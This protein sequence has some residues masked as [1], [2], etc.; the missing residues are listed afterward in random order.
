MIITC[1]HCQTRYQVTYEAIGATGRKVQCATCSRN[2]QQEPPTEADELH[3]DH[4]EAQIDEDKLDEGFAE[5][6]RAVAL[7]LERR[8]EEVA[9]AHSV[10]EPAKVDPA[11]QRKR[12]RAF[13][14]RQ[15][16]QF[17]KL[18][19]AR[20]RRAARLSGALI[21]A[22]L[23]VG[24]VFA[25]TTIVQQ[26]PAMAGVYSA[27]GLGVNV[28]G[29][30]F[31]DVTTL[32]TLVD[33]K[34]LLI[35]TATIKG[36]VNAP[37][38]VPPVVVSLIDGGG[39]PIYQWSVKP[40]AGDL[41][42]GETSALKTQL[43]LPPGDVARVKLAFAGGSDTTNDPP[44]AADAAPAATPHAPAEPALPTEHH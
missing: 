40:D 20:L 43:T 19:L 2:W 18:P 23:L 32:R 1:P 13:K 3:K 28:V 26:F 29:L 17:A 5:E 27:V 7:E 41:M 11:V 37:V 16:S 9:R 24:A 31:Q 38:P 35:V 4:L 34:E 30:T 44:A 42:A 8:L 21:L 6:E 25:R 36:A 22:S 12:Q 15:D 39:R 33:G 10:A 14:Q